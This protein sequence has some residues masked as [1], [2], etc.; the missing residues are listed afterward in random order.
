MA[1]E[2]DRDGEG[3]FEGRVVG[4]D[5][6]VEFQLFATRFKKRS[7]DQ[8]TSVGGHEVDDLRCGVACSDQK[9]TFVFAVFIVHDNDD[10]ATANRFDGFGNRIQLRHVGQR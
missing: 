7:T 10:F 1:H 8:P 4:L 6:Q 3:G 2:I 9:V 5:H